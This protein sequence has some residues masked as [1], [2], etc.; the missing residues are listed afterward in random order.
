[1]MNADFRIDLFICV[2]QRR[3]AAKLPIGVLQLLT[4]LVRIS[5][6]VE[7]HYNPPIISAGIVSFILVMLT[8]S[9]QHSLTQQM[10]PTSH[11]IN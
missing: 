8:P 1:M 7:C 11:V 4:Y 9:K 5:H 3:S 2:Q 10:R 6:F